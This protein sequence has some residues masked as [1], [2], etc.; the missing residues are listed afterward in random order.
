MCV[1]YI[2]TTL[3]CLRVRRVIRVVIVLDLKSHICS[4]SSQVFV[5]ILSYSRNIL[6]GPK[7]VYLFL[8]H[9]VTRPGAK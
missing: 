6:S 2:H 5:Y 1:Q 4:S 7:S 9:G 8:G 3:S